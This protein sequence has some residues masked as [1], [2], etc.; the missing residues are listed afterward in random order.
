MP[1][2]AC[3]VGVDCRCMLVSVVGLDGAHA[4][5]LWAHESATGGVAPVGHFGHS[6]M[7]SGELQ[8]LSQLVMCVLIVVVCLSVVCDSTELIRSG[9]GRTN[10]EMWRQLVTSG[11]VT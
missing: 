5:W 3:N 2:T 1:A 8:S 10:R 4:E 6:P 11:T 7:S 9:C